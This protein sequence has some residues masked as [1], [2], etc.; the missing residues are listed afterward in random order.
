MIDYSDF[1]ANQ[2]TPKLNVTF[3]Q[4]FCIIEYRNKQFDDIK[5]T[6][7]HLNDSFSFFTE[8]ERRVELKKK[9]MK[10]I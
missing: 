9:E 8:L 5:E 2:Y 1:F 10:L 3:D 6:M 7:P 4:A